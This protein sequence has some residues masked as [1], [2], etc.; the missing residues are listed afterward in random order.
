ML[1]WV[2]GH[3]PDDPHGLGHF[4]GTALYEHANPLQGRHLDWG[5]LIYNYGRTEVVN[6]LIVERAVLAGALCHRRPARRCRG[7]HALSRLQ[8]A[9]RRLDPEQIWRPRKSRSHRFPAPVQH[10]SC[11][12]VFRKP[13]PRRRN[14]PR[15]RWCRGRS[16]V[17]GSASATNGTWGGCTTRSSYIGKDPIHRRHHHGDVAVRAALCV[18]GK[19]HPAA[20]A[21]RSRA[22]QALDPG[23][24]ARRR[25][26]ALRQSARLLSP[27]C[28]PIP[29]R[30]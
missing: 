6:F 22:R 7:L 26:A 27:S 5:T 16:T 21:R 19:F 17:A 23:P 4:D 12:R 8:P 28:S 11:S 10:R 30:S 20:V 13:P 29:A 18:F 1:D 25:L 3:F 2:P 15:G 24:D 14:R 9:R